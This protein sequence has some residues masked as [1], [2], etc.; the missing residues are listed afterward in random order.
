MR[1]RTPQRQQRP[2]VLFPGFLHGLHKSG[3]RALNVLS[4]F[5]KVLMIAAPVFD[6]LR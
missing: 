3:P 6:D 1:H 5:S 4:T 2:L